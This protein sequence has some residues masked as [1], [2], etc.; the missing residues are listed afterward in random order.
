MLA[1]FT[2]EL[3]CCEPQHLSVAG[4]R[5]APDK[6]MVLPLQVLPHAPQLLSSAFASTQVLLQA[7]CPA[8]H[9]QTP[10]AQVAPVAHLVPHLPQLALLACTSMQA[11][12]APHVLC[13]AGQMQALC[14]QL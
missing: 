4:S 2:H 13:P 6:H 12:L 8:G 7:I 3:I 9:A 10:A 14:Q 5:H 11:P 1:S